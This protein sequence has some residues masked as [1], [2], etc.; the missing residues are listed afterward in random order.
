VE[1]ISDPEQKEQIVAQMKESLKRGGRKSYAYAVI[2]SYA[3]DRSLNGKSV[4]EAARLKR[5]SDTLDEQIELILEIEKN[6]GAG[7]VFHG[8]A[9]EDLQLFLRHPNTMIASDGG[10][11]EIDD[12]VPHPRSYGNN[13]RA[14]ARYVRDLKLLCL[15]DAVR[16]MTSLPATTFRLR[17]RGLIREG[18]WADLAV[19]DPATVQDT[20]TYEAPHQ[21]ATGIVHVFVNGVAVVKNGQPTEARPGKALRNAGYRGSVER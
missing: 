21:Y 14:L 13:A 15:E 17:D 5:G 18:C 12:S 3:A 6:G 20:A 2:A 8:I 7:A 11:R 1:R 10:V 4:A 9:E 16:R 19:F